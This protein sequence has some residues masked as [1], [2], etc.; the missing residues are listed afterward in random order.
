MLIEDKIDSLAKGGRF[1]MEG[2]G[3]GKEED[4]M[5]AGVFFASCGGGKYMPLLRLL[6]DNRCK[7]NCYYCP[8]R[9]SADTERGFITPQEIVKYFFDLYQRKIVKG[10]FLSSSVW[11]SPDRSMEPIIDTATI[12]RKKG[13]NGYIHLKIIPGSSDSTIEEAIKYASRVS[14]NLEAPSSTHLSVLSPQKKFDSMLMDTLFRTV[15]L[16]EKVDPAR[17]KVTIT[18]QYVVGPAQETDKDLLSTTYKL[19]N[20]GWIHRAYYSPFFIP[21]PNSPL[22]GMKP[23]SWLRIARIY[24]ADWLIKYYKFKL[25]ELPF[26]S[27]G[28]LPYQ[29]DPKLGWAIKHP[30]FF[31]IEIN[32]ATKEELLRV[33]GLGPTSV[34]IIVGVRR[35]ERIKFPQQLRNITSRWKLA[36][37]FLLFDG[38]RYF[39]PVQLPLDL[40]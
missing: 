10:I 34:N 7:Y 17:K 15:K 22:S 30:E 8:W 6:T 5:P 18:T 9:S 31:P 32:N 19:Y 3:Y 26:D 35:K 11:Q 23:T 14:I 38:K 33:P 28:Y 36:T 40:I 27:R 39:Y 16:I 29:Y 12:L 25:E 13:F 2:L 24:Q 37:N 4:G 1:E 21:D 20:K